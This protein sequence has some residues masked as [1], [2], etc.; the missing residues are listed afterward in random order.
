MSKMATKTRTATGAAL[1]RQQLID[2]LSQKRGATFVTVTTRTVP[3]MR[4][5]GNPFVGKVFKIS[6]VNGTAWHIYANSVNNQ[7]EREGSVAANF[8]ALPRVWGTR[9]SQT[10]L[11]E[12]KGNFYLEL[13]VESSLG[14]RYVN[15]A[16]KDLTPDE[17]ERLKPFLSKPRQAATQQTEKEIILRDYRIE[18]IIAIAMDSQKFIIVPL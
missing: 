3:S 10:S 11:V 5:T 18:N 16:G 4:K 8:E 13:K 2:K 6:K 15:S 17:V 9:I 7:R 1:T 14:H 12:H